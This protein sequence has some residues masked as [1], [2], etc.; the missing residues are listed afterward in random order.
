[1]KRLVKVIEWDG[2]DISDHPEFCDSY[3]SKAT[4]NTGVLLNNVELEEVNNNLDDYEII[5]QTNIEQLF[6]NNSGL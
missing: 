6:N 1:M 5:G 3:I 2:I 4:W